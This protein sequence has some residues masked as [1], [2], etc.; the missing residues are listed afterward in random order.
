MLSIGGFWSENHCRPKET[1]SPVS[2]FLKNILTMSG[3][4]EVELSVGSGRLAFQVTDLALGSVWTDLF[5]IKLWH[6]KIVK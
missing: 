4:I 6:F 3:N 5:D 2:Q 1:K